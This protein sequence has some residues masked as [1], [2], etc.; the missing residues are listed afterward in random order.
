M[1]CKEKMRPVKDLLKAL[2]D[3]PIQT[4]WEQDREKTAQEYLISI[5]R[6]IEK[7]LAEMQQDTEKMLVWHK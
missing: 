3:N 6:H 5:G 4:P 1:Q 2:Y 7:C